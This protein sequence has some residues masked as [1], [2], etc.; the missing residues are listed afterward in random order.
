MDDKCWG[1]SKRPVAT[2]VTQSE[3]E[4][5]MNECKEKRWEM[6]EVWED[7]QGFKSFMMMMMMI[8]S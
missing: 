2:F 4:W 3:S 8:K 6:V 5:L 1:E 7:F